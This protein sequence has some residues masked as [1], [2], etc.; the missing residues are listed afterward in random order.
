VRLAKGCSRL[1][2]GQGGEGVA[3]DEGCKKVTE[4]WAQWTDDTL[5]IGPAEKT[6]SFRTPPIVKGRKVE[7]VWNRL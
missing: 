6:A 2:K 4:D 3:A 1:D 5:G 7:G